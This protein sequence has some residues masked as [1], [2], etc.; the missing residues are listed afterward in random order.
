MKLCRDC[1]H[2]EASDETCRRARGTP[3]Y[4]HGTPPERV[5]ARIERGFS[6]LDGCGPEAKHFEPKTV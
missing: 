4:V 1:K 6:L 3:D 5:G 2:F